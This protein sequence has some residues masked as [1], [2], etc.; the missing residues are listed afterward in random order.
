MP[1][2]MARQFGSFLGL[3]LDYDAK[4]MCLGGKQLMRLKFILDVQFPLKRKKEEKFCLVRVRVKVSKIVFCWNLLPRS[5]TRRGT[6]AASCWLRESDG[7]ATQ[8]LDKERRE[9]RRNRGDNSRTIYQN[10]KPNLIGDT[11]PME[12]GSGA[13]DS[14]IPIVDGQPSTIKTLTWNVHGLGHL[15]IVNR[16]NNKLKDIHPQILFLMET[17]AS[18]KGMKVVRHKCDFGNGI[19]AGA[20]CSRGGLS[21]GWRQDCVASLRSYSQHHIDAVVSDGEVTDGSWG[22]G[23]LGKLGGYRQLIFKNDLIGDFVMVDTIGRKCER[24]TMR[25]R[26]KFRFD[27]NWCLEGFCAEEVRQFWSFSLDALQLKLEGLGMLGM[28]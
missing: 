26:F 23:S 15:G 9:I 1:K 4:M 25:G 16:L 21:L 10:S 24:K 13:K 18:V 22:S 19:D 28:P 11:W 12:L 2:S 14:P 20:I 8:D 7:T 27:A 6:V 3:F 5:P 17:K